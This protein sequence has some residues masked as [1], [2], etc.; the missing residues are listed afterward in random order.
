[1]NNRVSVNQVNSLLQAAE[2]NMEKGEI[3][4]AGTDWI[5]MNG[6]T[7]RTLI[8]GSEKI[9]GSGAAP[10]WFEAGKHAGQEFSENLVR[11]GMPVHELPKA[12]EEF[13]TK[14][15]WG[16][17]LAKVDFA[18]EEALV[19]I[20]NSVTARGIKATAPVCYSIRGF[21]KGVCDVIFQ[22]DTECMEA[23]CMATGDPYC[24]F[25]VKRT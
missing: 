23:R 13:F 22:G 10:V 8:Q 14:G 12:F 2:C 3:R 24:E 9:L 25:R 16:S 11:L 1:M 21:I 15:G 18:K 4:I 20:K 5:L 17:V 6:A 19:T 7:F